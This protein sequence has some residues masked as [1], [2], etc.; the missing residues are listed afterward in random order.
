M[1]KNKRNIII[2]AGAATLTIVGGVA[3]F[4]GIM[5]K[6][7]QSN[8]P[9]GSELLP[10]NAVMAI[11]LTTDDRQ[12]VK[13]RQFGTPES[14]KLFDSQLAEL[15]DRFLSNNGYDYLEDIKPWIGREITIGFLP[16]PDLKLTDTQEETQVEAAS[17]AKQSMVILLPIANAARA[18]KFLESPKPL[19][20]GEWL[21]RTYKG[22]QIKETVGRTLENY[23][24]SALDGRYLAIANRR[25]AIDRTIDTYKGGSTLANSAGFDQAWT[26]IE[27]SRTFAQFYLN[28][29]VAAAVT[30]LSLDDSITPQ[31]LAQVQQQQGIVANMTLESQGVRFHG[32][33]WLKSNSDR[34]YSLPNTVDNILKRLPAETSMVLSGQNLQQLW[35]EYV[36]GAQGNPLAPFQP[37]WSRTAIQN[38][39]KLDLEK[40]LLSWMAGQFALSLLPAGEGNE[41]KFQAAVV[42]MVEASDRRAGEKIF[43]QL[44][45]LMTKEYNFKVEPDKIGEQSVVNWTSEYGSLQVTHGWLEGDLAFLIFGAP[46]GEQLIPKPTKSL[47]LDQEFQQAVSTQLSPNNGQFFIDVESTINSNE[48]SWLQLPPNQQTMVNG[49]RSIGVTA[50]NINP[51]TSQ[52]EIF[53]RLKTAGQPA[54]LPDPK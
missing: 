18:K 6:Q 36:Q 52:Y 13:L 41:S 33:G 49:I 8:G 23:S 9:V 46:L 45:E 44:D 54:P 4:W 40:D 28:V 51:R 14:Q 19:A 5:T 34:K 21:D 25:D 24:I 37:E 31:S 11:S 1:E 7:P 3:T 47:G 12:W 30:S 35:Q 42:F 26:T 43:T 50:A 38:T 48:P 10:D 29:P 16:P 53:V 2:A 17:L 15:R 22:V 20:E 39:T 27:K 32:L